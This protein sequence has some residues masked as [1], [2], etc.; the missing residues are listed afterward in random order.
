MLRIINAR[1]ADGR[2]ATIQT[3]GGQIQAVTPQKGRQ[4][5]GRDVLR[6]GDVGDLNGI[7]GGAVLDADGE[8]ILPGLVDVHIHSREPGFPHKE[9]WKDMAR[10]AYKGGVVAVCDMPNT[11]PP[12]MDRE[13]V[14]E[15]AA[16]ARESGLDFALYLG[17]GAGN[18]ERLPEL[19]ADEELPLCG[20]KI[21]YGQSTG[22][23]MYSDLE[24]L[25]Q[26]LPRATG[27]V[28]AFHSED[29]CHIDRNHAGMDPGTCTTPDSFAVHSRIRSSEAAMSSAR[30]ILDW[31]VR[32]NRAIHIAHLSTPG[33]VG[34]IREARARGG[35]I[36]SEVAPHHLLF[37]TDDYGRLGSRIKM[38]PPVRSPE[39]VRD[40]RRCYG[41]GRIEIFATDH[42]PHTLEEK[43]VREYDRCPSGVPAL[44]FF[45][46]LLLKCAEISGMSTESAVRSAAEVPARVFGF[47]RTGRLA[48][49]FDANLVW[50]REEEQI[51]RDKEL[52]SKCGWTP[53]DGLPLPARVMSTWHKGRLVYSADPR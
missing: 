47:P 15:K 1:M 37:S 40:L 34:L 16:I 53:Y 29:Q 24:K 14:L 45:L 9:T 3:A 41:E 51:P 44:E 36:T 52:L 8:L 13:S 19:L 17:V 6:L 2:L 11:L 38:N 33:E 49:G 27:K 48:P 30:T 28:L 21:Y 50:V 39:E 31:A 5:A 7:N 23:L 10:A 26:T 35:R 18:L 32:E 46:P 42:A 43:A 25:G 12:T 4:G 22:E 20:L